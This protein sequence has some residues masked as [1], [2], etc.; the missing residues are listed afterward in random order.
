MGVDCAGTIVALGKNVSSFEIGDEVIGWVDYAYSGTFAE[1][2]IAKAK[3]VIQ[4]P[5]S[6]SFEEAAVLPMVACTALIALVQQAKIQAGMKVLI[7]GCTGGVGHVAVQIAKAYGA[8]VIGTC[9]QQNFT[10]AIEIG[11]ADVVD[12]KSADLQ[13]YQSS[14]DIVLDTPGMLPYS[15]AKNLMTSNGTFVSINPK[16]EMLWGIISNL[17]NNQHYKL[18]MAK[19]NHNL[20]KEIQHLVNKGELHPIVGKVFPFSKAIDA[21]QFAENGGKAIGKVVMSMEN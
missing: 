2:V 9:S 5:R 11:V 16:P 3:L 20:L 21:V 8:T 18:V 7:N 14:F 12:Y 4:K 1:Y 6:I 17:W 13:N 10:K 19:A 15:K